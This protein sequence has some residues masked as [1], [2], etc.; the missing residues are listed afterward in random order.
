M[1]D[2]SHTNRGLYILG[3]AFV[4]QKMFLCLCAGMGEANLC[5]ETLGPF[6]PNVEQLR[7]QRIQIHLQPVAH[8]AASSSSGSSGSYH[9]GVCKALTHLVS[10][11]HCCTWY[12]CVADTTVFNGLLLDHYGQITPASMHT[13]QVAALHNI[14][15]LQCPI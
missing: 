6:M 5:M 1:F 15:A 4:Q 7:A 11:V 3:P 2:V 14:L 9:P 10:L 13:G 8:G 12:V